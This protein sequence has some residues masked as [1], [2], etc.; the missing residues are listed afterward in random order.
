M[1]ATPAARS[2]PPA[3]IRLMRL[4]RPSLVFL[5]A[6]CAAAGARA[7]FHDHLG[8]Q[9]YSLRVQI[10]EQGLP[11]ALDLAK[12]Y[13][14]T[15]VE[16]GVGAT[17]PAAAQVRAMLDAR[18]LVAPSVHAQY[19]DLT[20]DLPGVIRYARTLGASIVICPWIPHDGAFDAA[21]MR[22][23][24]ADFN[25]WGAACRAAGLRFGYHPHGYEFAP[26]A[27]AG[28]TL[29]DDLIRATRPDDVGYE[30]DVFW[31]VHGGGDP[32]AL[33]RKYPTRWVALHVKD[34]RPGTATGLT[35]G[36]AQPADNVAVGAGRIDWKA[37]I[38]AAEKAGVKYYFIE[39]ETPDPLRC[40]PASL[41]Y[42][43]ALQP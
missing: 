21:R 14:V 20:K 34:M 8:L 2:R 37:V 36:H 35:T 33:L 19:D 32:V 22:Q 25:R 9:L 18:G 26:G 17:W 16:G 1:A 11:A 31:V 5:A 3:V 41:T 39:D 40:I 7:D 38:G 27:A 12:S 24:A 28:E 29:L 43:R 42:L 10:K 4:P 15:E 23:A 13:G 30:M 6:A